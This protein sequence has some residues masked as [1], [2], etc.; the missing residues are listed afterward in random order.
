[1]EE[2]TLNSFLTSR[3]AGIYFNRHELTI[4]KIMHQYFE[5][6]VDFRFICAGGT[7]NSEM[8]IKISSLEDYFKNPAKY[9]V[10]TK[11]HNKT[12]ISDRCFRI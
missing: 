10:L 7:K 2:L 11:S 4:N 12:H 1:M 6:G 5:E 9:K 8:L 3:E